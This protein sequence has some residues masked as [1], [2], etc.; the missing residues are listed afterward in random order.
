MIR[1]LVLLIALGLVAW[2]VAFLPLPAP[3]PQVIWVV[4]VLC[5]IWEVLAL[6]GYVPSA[7]DR[8]KGS[9]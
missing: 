4:M 6:A 8:W 9:P 7:L 2:L 3:F 1:L 5:V